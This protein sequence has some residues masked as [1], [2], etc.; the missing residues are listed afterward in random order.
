M[1]HILSSPPAPV[2]PSSLATHEPKQPSTKDVREDVIHAGTTATTLPKS[3]FSIS[4]IE[5]LFLWVCQHL[6][7][8]TDLFELQ[9]R[10]KQ[11]QNLLKMQTRD[12]W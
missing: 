6:V 12:K 1:D 4:I 7:G 5:L 2:A 9:G 8:K 11:A 10:R 3:L